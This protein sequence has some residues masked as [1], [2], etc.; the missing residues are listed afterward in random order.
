LSRWSTL[1]VPATFK[2]KEL[3]GAALTT[4]ALG[5]GALLPVALIRRRRSSRRL[6]ICPTSSTEHV[7]AERCDRD[8]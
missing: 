2:R 4:S 7:A 6:R 1:P 8:A 3:D 5:V